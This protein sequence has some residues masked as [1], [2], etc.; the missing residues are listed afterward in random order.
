[1]SHSPAESSNPMWNIYKMWARVKASWAHDDQILIQT[2]MPHESEV[3]AA[4]ALCNF[5][6]ALD[7]NSQSLHTEHTGT[8]LSNSKHHLKHIDVDSRGLCVRNFS[9]LLYEKHAS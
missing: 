3:Q 7:E 1:M 4:L 9:V 6:A 5:T 8:P 2:Q